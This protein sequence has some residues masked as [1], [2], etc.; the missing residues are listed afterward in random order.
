MM[1][2]RMNTERGVMNENEWIVFDEVIAMAGSLRANGNLHSTNNGKEITLIF[3]TYEIIYDH[4]LQ[5]KRNTC[6]E[7]NNRSPKQPADLEI[8]CPQGV[9]TDRA[10]E[11]GCTEK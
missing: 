10:S 1:L 6:A 4:M 9:H 7:R 5:V 2:Y 3:D 11:S 8:S